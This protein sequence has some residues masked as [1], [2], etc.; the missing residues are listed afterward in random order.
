MVGSGGVGKDSQKTNI[1]Y[2]I[3]ID[4]H[5]LNSA[6][7]GQFPCYG[8]HFV[9]MSELNFPASLAARTLSWEPSPSFSNIRTMQHF[10]TQGITSCDG[11]EQNSSLG[12][13]GGSTNHDL[14][15]KVPWT[16]CFRNPAVALCWLQASPRNKKPVSFCCLRNYSKL[17]GIKHNPHSSIG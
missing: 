17:S 7:M 5:D 15:N 12:I 6:I 9:Y 2:E 8:L 14:T 10:S 16:L 4:I 11:H 1:C 3:S 13:Y